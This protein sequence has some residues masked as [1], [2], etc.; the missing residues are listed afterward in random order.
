MKTN[1][2]L[3]FVPFLLIFLAMGIPQKL[4]EMNYQAYLKS[5]KAE[6]KQNVAY[7][8]KIHQEN[9]SDETLFQLALTEY[10]LLNATMADNDKKLF[11]DYADACQERLESLTD[12]KKF[13][14][15]AKALLS[16]VY[17][18]KIAYS[19]LK[20]MM[21]GPKSSTLL[22]QAM[23][24]NPS[25]PIVLKMY[26]ANQYFTPEMWGGDKETALKAFEKSTEFFQKNKQEKTWM[27]LDNLAWTGMI[28][29]EKGQPDKAK[30]TWE[31]ALEIEPNFYW[32]SKSLLPSLD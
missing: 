32:V 7:A 10:G 20:G 31:K 21:Y 19:P 25:S 9:P 18:Y 23:E 11:S 29:Q 2:K 12:S 24:E 17:G 22:D 5:D 6:W 28:Y 16:G 14:S 1:S 13:G 4:E 15:E 3:V 27:N 26:A 30:E 8:L